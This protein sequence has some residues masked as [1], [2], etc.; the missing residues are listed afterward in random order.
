M[1]GH[2]LS[3]G[4]DSMQSSQRFSGLFDATLRWTE[5][6]LFIPEPDPPV[7]DALLDDSSLTEQLVARARSSFRVHRLEECWSPVSDFTLRRE[8][9]PVTDTHSFWSRK[10]LLSGLGEP[11]VMAHSL[12]PAHSACS[13]LRQV[14]ELGDK[15]LGRYLFTQ[16]DLLRANLKLATTGSGML[17]RRSVFYLFSK[18]IMVAEFFTPEYLARL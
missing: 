13:E 8:F 16:P 15:P 7:R 9:G 4:A 5:P 12:M 18:P 3:C 17:G 6:D 10:V 11:W 14:L 1:A 2:G